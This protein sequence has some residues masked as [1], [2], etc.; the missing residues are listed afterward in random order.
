MYICVY[1]RCLKA[2]KVCD[3]I[4]VQMMSEDG[5]F[6]LMFDGVSKTARPEI[7][8][9]NEKDINSADH[10]SIKSGMQKVASFHKGANRGETR[11]YETPRMAIDISSQKPDI[12]NKTYSKLSGRY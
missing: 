1:H 6:E 4:I 2:E 12:D 8:E 3:S 10:A 7:R 11:E 5:D 9:S